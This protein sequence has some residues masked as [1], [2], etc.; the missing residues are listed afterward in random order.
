M[1]TPMLLT[2]MLLAAAPARLERLDQTYNHETQTA[3]VTSGT[4][5]TVGHTQTVEQ[6]GRGWEPSDLDADPG[7]GPPPPPREKVCATF[8]AQWNVFNPRL[9][10]RYKTVCR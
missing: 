1:I 4:R 7:A 5:W 6:T 9:C 3:T 2:P 8:C 10:F